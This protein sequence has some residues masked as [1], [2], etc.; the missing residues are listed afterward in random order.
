MTPEMAF[1]CFLVSRDTAVVCILDPILRDFSICTDVCPDPTKVVDIL[2]QVSADLLVIDLEDKSSAELV[3][4]VYEPDIHQKPTILAVSAM[5]RATRG[6]HVVLRKPVTPESGLRSLKTA[7]SRMLEDFRKHTRFAVMTSVLATGENNRTFPLM[8]TNVGEGG[9]GLATKKKIP[10]G[11]IL[12]FQM[13]LPGLKNEICIRA[14][15]L[16]TREYGAAGCE[17]VSLSSFDGQLLRA[18]L[19][20]RYRIKKPLIP[21]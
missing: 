20:S 12:S 1:Q 5:D 11:S 9:V 14:R 7:Y 10:I 2:G 16:W 15:V 19:E 8:V 18:W 13:P 17:F 3:S 21:V 4:R 6:V